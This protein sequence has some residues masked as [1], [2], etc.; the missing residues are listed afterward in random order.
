MMDKLFISYKKNITIQFIID[1]NLFCNNIILLLIFTLKS[2]LS[3]SIIY[4]LCG[5]KCILYVNH[6][7]NFDINIIR[8]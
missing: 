7:Y 8:K 1:E 6:K 3:I 2:Y 4:V 5:V